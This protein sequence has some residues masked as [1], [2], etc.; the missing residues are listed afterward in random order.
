MFQHTFTH[1]VMIH[2]VIFSHKVMISVFF[3][4]MRWWRGWWI[5][6]VIY[7][8]TLRQHINTSACLCFSSY[9]LSKVSNLNC[10]G[11]YMYFY[12]LS[13]SFL[14]FET[15]EMAVQLWNGSVM[16]K[17]VYERILQAVKFKRS[18]WLLSLLSAAGWCNCAIW[19]S[20]FYDRLIHIFW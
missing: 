18:S 11:Q 10:I 17:E 6:C 1:P 13:T 5:L 7:S 14:Q 3:R 12:C 8:M 9:M 19:V 16:R 20:L 2:T 4:C 15:L